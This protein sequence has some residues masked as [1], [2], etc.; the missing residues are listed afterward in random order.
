VKA[1]TT[2]NFSTRELKSVLEKEFSWSDILLA[3]GK[4]WAS[5][6]TW[7]SGEGLGSCRFG[8]DAGLGSNIEVGQSF[9]MAL[10]HWQTGFQTASAREP[11]IFH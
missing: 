6:K 5:A 2:P 8:T 3:F 9:L 1:T 10:R 4:A 11:H 7:V